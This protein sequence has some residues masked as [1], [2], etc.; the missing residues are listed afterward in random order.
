[1]KESVSSVG[2]QTLHMYCRPLKMAFSKAAGS[3]PIEAYYVSYVE[4][5]ARPRTKLEVI[6]R[7]LLKIPCKTAHHKAWIPRH[8]MDGQDSGRRLIG[9][10]GRKGERG[11][12][13]LGIEEVLD[14]ENRFEVSMRQLD[15]QEIPFGQIK[16]EP[17]RRLDRAIFSQ[18]SDSE[19]GHLY[20]RGEALRPSQ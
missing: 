10:T 17:G 19:V 20:L 16:H 15:R 13:P 6:F 3:K 4:M 8:E 12:L 9:Q 11:L 2:L 7:G 14:V 5:G 1:M 18:V